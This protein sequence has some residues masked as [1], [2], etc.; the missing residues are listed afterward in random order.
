VKS[1]D[2]SGTVSALSGSCPA[3]TFTIGASA[4]YT[5]PDTDFSKGK[6][7]DMANGV[8]VDIKGMLMSDG[9]V[10]ADKVTLKRGR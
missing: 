2:L 8:D 6:C 5:T 3:L 10:R 9:R 1:I 7:S 4:V